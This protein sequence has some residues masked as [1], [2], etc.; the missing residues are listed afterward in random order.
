MTN[1]NALWL[2]V[3]VHGLPQH[4]DSKEGETGYERFIG[5]LWACA[6]SGQ[7]YICV[8]VVNNHEVGLRVSIKHVLKRQSSVPK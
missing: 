1:S 6:T 5:M 8:Y 7:L 3:Q 4:D 2:L